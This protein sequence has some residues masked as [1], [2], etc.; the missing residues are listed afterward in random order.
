MNKTV[1]LV[2]IPIKD[3]SYYLS[4]QIKINFLVDSIII[5]INLIYFGNK[6]RGKT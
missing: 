3:F 6:V 5:I 1:F 2:F 4:I